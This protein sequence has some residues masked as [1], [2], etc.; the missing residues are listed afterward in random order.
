MAVFNALQKR[1]GIDQPP[2]PEQGRTSENPLLPEE[3][4]EKSPSYL[5]ILQRME[6]DIIAVE[7]TR[8]STSTKPP[9]STLAPLGL[10]SQQEWESLFHATIDAGD[11]HNARRVVDLMKR[12]GVPVEQ[13]LEDRLLFSFVFAKDVEGVNAYIEEVRS[14][15]KVPTEVQRH[16]HVEALVVSRRFDEAQKLIHHYEGEGLVPSQST[17]RN[18][19]GALFAAS[20]P[21]TSPHSP[22]YRALAWDMF[23][24]MRYV[25]HPTPSLDTY[26]IMLR[27]CA[28]AISPSPQRA[29]DLFHEMTVENRIQPTTATYNAVMLTC[30]RSG[31]RDYMH[32]AYRL[33][34]Q[35]LDE[36]RHLPDDGSG[37]KEQLQ[38]D[39]ETF[40]AMLEAAKRM[41]DLP[42]ARWILAELVRL[43]ERVDEE[44]MG[45]VFHVYASFKPSFQR[46]AVPTVKQEDPKQNLTGTDPENLESEPRTPSIQVQPH[47]PL[48]PQSREE[49]LQEAQA[50]FRRILRGQEV[51]QMGDMWTDISHPDWPFSSVKITTNLLNAYLSV[52]LNHET[53]EKALPL[54][55]SEKES[56][57]KRFHVT[58][59]SQSFAMVLERLAVAKG[60]HD[61]KK[62]MTLAEEVWQEWVAFSTKRENNA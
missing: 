51:A 48:V 19:I 30:S 43:G 37:A 55:I 13:S 38:P 7:E 12:S 62:A 6:G 10:A 39:L 27:A 20:K 49:V 53:P 3:V 45:H 44:L 40:K 8:P 1:F 29:L 18:F 17:Y 11:R 32:E 35:L 2:S 36:Y 41:G 9:T 57:Y 42:R 50:L 25:A 61:R 16:L 4:S 14:R 34:K 33:G 58:K 24:H 46:G 54:F 23:A 56:L 15:G 31:R 60:R 22:Q 59:N 47:A 21:S 28:D 52:H 26:N 5:D